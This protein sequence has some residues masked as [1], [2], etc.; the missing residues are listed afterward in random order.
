MDAV[1]RRK[2]LIASGVLGGGAVGLGAAI[3]LADLLHRAK[4]QDPEEPGDNPDKLVV[5]TLYG[6]NDGLATVVPHGDDAY[7]SARPELAYAS[8]QVLDLNGTL[9]LNPALVGLKKLWDDGQLAIVLGVGYPQPDRSHFHSMDVW[10]TASPAH[11]IKSGWVGRWLDAVKGPLETAVSFEPVLPPLLVGAERSG[12]SVGVSGLQLPAG[13]TSDMLARLGQVVP[14]EPMIGARA[15]AGIRDL[16]DIDRLVREA[17]RAERPSTGT[18]QEIPATGTGG[19]SALAAQLNL[20]ASCVEAG[21]RTRVYSVSLGGFDLHAQE[22]AG[23][24]MLLRE[25]DQ[26]LT[27]FVQRLSATQAG[28]RVTV[29]VYSEFGRRVRANSAFGTDHG[30]AG[31]MFVLGPHVAGGLHG[32]QPS[33]TDLDDGDLKMTTDFRDVFGSIIESVL[34]PDPERFLEGHKLRP[35]PLIKKA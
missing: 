33:L 13:I 16:L 11:P 27:P 24:E 9:G 1:T 12:V 6:G 26:A 29:V 34:H 25:L 15:A 35:I 20:V 30:T 4:A 10:Q 8:G 5:V 17:E 31:P 21:V 19:E 14:G 28:R 32:V 23:Q 7:Q 3:G 2:F 18:R 22:R